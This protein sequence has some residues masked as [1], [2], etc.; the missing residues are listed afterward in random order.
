MSD[1]QVFTN[2]IDGEERPATSGDVLDILLDSVSTETPDI[3]PLD[4][5]PDEHGKGALDS[6][7]ELGEHTTPA[8]GLSTDPK[9]H[10]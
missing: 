8:T 7:P 3:N 1:K 5:R 10:G 9:T 6:Q 2:I 4:S